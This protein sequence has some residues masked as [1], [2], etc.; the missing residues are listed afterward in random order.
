MSPDFDQT[1]RRYVYD[2]FVQQQRPPTVAE[3]AA[4]LQVSNDEA[5]AAYQRLHQGHVVVLEPD[6]TEIRFAMPFCAVP[7][8]FRVHAKGHAWWGTCAWDAL[9]IAAALHAD[10][11]IITA[12]ADCGESIILKVENGELANTGGVIHFALPAKQWWD[13]IFFT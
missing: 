13:D 3:T 5:E 4:A 8:A 6:K 12:C 7:T 11:K 10:A 9:G 2:H 1:V